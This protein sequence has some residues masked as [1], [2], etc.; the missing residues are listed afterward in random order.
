VLSSQARQRQT[1]Q[2]I[3]LGRNP[4]LY[5][6]KKDQ[7]QRASQKYRERVKKKLADLEA[8]KAEAAAAKAEAAAVA[9]EMAAVT[10]KN[11]ELEAEIVAW[12]QVNAALPANGPGGQ[13]RL[14][15]GFLNTTTWTD[16]ALGEAVC[17]YMCMALVLRVA[18][19]V[20]YARLD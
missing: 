8:A 5:Q 16:D 15:G 9:A 11:A 2:V 1:P 4:G 7:T 3:E 10:A 17:A 13:M 20:G 14:R 19:G 6:K 18:H 12:K